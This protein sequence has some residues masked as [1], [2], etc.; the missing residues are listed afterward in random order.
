[1]ALQKFTSTRKGFDI[2]PFDIAI[3]DRSAYI[4]RL[5]ENSQRV[6]DFLDTVPKAIQDSIAFSRFARQYIEFHDGL[7]KKSLFEVNKG[8]TIRESRA[9]QQLEDSLVGIQLERYEA[10]SSLLNWY[11][12]EQKFWDTRNQFMAGRIEEIAL[13]NPGK[14][15]IVLT[16]VSHKYYLLD[17]LRDRSRMHLISY[18]A[19]KN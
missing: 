16:G 6:F 9:L 8:E 17:L 12:E 5:M 13:S 10:D 19:D 14:L 18:I 4:K 15:I 7:E 11:L 1:L 2:L 3:A